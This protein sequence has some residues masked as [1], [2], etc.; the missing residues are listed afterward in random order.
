MGDQ[1]PAEDERDSTTRLHR[2]QASL[3][4]IG[5]AGW[6]SA[7]E[8]VPNAI[9]VYDA[10]RRILYLNRAGRLGAGLTHE[11][12]VG[13]LDSEVFPAHATREY[14]SLLELAFSSR[15]PV[16]G[17]CCIL[18]SGRDG[19]PARPVVF[20][21][22]YTPILDSAGRL[23]CLVGIT[24]DL[25]LTRRFENE[26][27]GLRAILVSSGFTLLTV[28][29][30]G[31]I[32]SLDR[33]SEKTYGYFA[34]E[35]IGQSLATLLETRSSRELE[36]LLSRVA[37]GEVVEYEGRRRHKSGRLLELGL[38]L[39]PVVNQLG[40]VVAISECARDISRR[41]ELERRV[42]SAPHLE[43]VSRAVAGIAHELNN[44]LTVV[45]N[46]SALL[47]EDPLLETQRLDLE[48]SRR[49]GRRAA[50]LV[51]QLLALHRGPCENER[52]VDLGA[53]LRELSGSLPRLF[54]SRVSC[55]APLER[56][57]V[58]A[59]TL[60]IQQ[61]VL[62]L[63]N[64]AELACPGAELLVTAEASPKSSDDPADHATVSVVS[65]EGRPP[66]PAE[67]SAEDTEAWLLGELAAELGARFSVAH[68]GPHPFEARV[69]LA[70]VEPVVTSARERPRSEPAVVLL[71]EDDPDIRAALCRILKRKGYSVLV[72]ADA[73]QA[74]QIAREHRGRID[75]MLSD[76]LLPDAKGVD[77]IAGVRALWPKLRAVLVSGHPD[78]PEAPPDIEFLQKPFS[79]DD[80]LA[81]VERVLAEPDRPLE[82][83]PSGRPVVLVV[84][85]DR[86]VLQSMRRLLAECNLV[87][88]TAPSGLHALQILQ[89]RQVDAVVADQVMPGMG[90]LHLLGI[91]RERWPEAARMLFTAH[92]ASEVVLEAV[93]QG[94]AQKVLLKGMHALQIRNEIESSALGAARRPARS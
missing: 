92:P 9:V 7:L 24:N 4:G 81:T 6:F 10:E 53:V 90:G 49:A 34:D 94:A 46:Y 69:R 61:L 31:T 2:A 28:A 73:A 20:S 35:L 82:A 3:P 72:A 12:V 71:A 1:F 76:Q 80:L 74:L 13:R 59:D 51:R 89:E 36:E 87:T 19:S 23:E 63:I 42:L 40:H 86:Q 75:L 18:T 14:L 11:Q 79:M 29:L 33:G 8:N 66:L 60:K 47:Q 16:T 17:E 39:S 88:L 52:S 85:D 38:T 26:A 22:S 21:V 25:T 37:R 54:G 5:P 83:I 68:A 43:T 58:R 93:N 32:L 57:I 48:M 50:G 65:R 15:Q 64:Y 77:T 41:R 62:A 84:D 91:V 78:R 67:Q 44:A 45:E 56:L 55:E 70:L 27:S 30:D